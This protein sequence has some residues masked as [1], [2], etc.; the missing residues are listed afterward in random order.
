MATFFWV[1]GIIVLVTAAGRRF[2]EHSFIPPIVVYII[3]GLL[4]NGLNMQ[5]HFMN[6]HVH[7]GI[8]LM[9]EIGIVILLFRVGLESKLEHLVGQLKR[10]S[11]IWLG[12]V[13]VSAVIGFV[14]AR[15]VLGFSLIASLFLAV[16]LSAT[17]VGIS[18]AL[19]QAHGRLDTPEGALLI[20]VAELDDISAVMMMS[21][22]F[23]MAPTLARS[24]SVSLSVIGMEILVL[25]GKL[26]LFLMICF[27]F[28]RYLESHIMSFF[29]TTSGAS[30]FVAAL[31]VLFVISGLAG[32]LGYSLAIGAIFAGFSFSRDPAEHELDM[33]LDFLFYIFVPFFFVNIGMNVRLDLISSALPVGGV[34]FLAA[35][36]GKL[37]GTGL[38]A[39]FVLEKRETFILSL[40]MIP[41]AEIAMLI[42]LF[43]FQHELAFVS[44]RLFGGMVMVTILTCV[45]VPVV[46]HP[47]LQEQSSK[48]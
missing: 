41:R 14:A 29:H 25:L 11:F 15:F 31:G 17:S 10:A 40:S 4:C 22:L 8:S 38:P 3:V 46:L 1:F 44:P 6:K 19:W 45:F 27:L 12:N 13:S 2:L 35:C 48:D 37:V 34:L 32:A 20:D 7:E 33:Q 36:L 39:L 42:M 43:G 28:A 5:F 18:A 24:Q 21:V 26:A 23:S 16:A 47:L 30:T 9:A